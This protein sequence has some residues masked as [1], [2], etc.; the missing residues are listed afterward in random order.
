MSKKCTCDKCSP[1]ANT[2][3]GPGVTSTHSYNFEVDEHAIHVAAMNMPEGACVTI[4][5]VFTTCD[6]EMLGDVPSACGCC[7]TTLCCCTPETT[8]LY[9]GKYTA[10]LTGAEPD[11]VVVTWNPIKAAVNFTVPNGG[12]AMCC[13]QGM[14]VADVKAIVDACVAG[15]GNSPDTNVS[16]SPTADGFRVT[17]G[18]GGAPYDIPITHPD[19]PD[20]VAP[21]LAAITA[22]YASATVSE[23]RAYHKATKSAD[24]SGWVDLNGNYGEDDALRGT[25]GY[26][27]IAD[28]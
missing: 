1:D 28:L 5:R 27:N 14:S 11:D 2:L 24:G 8:L 21:T 17:P 13:N 6:G 23:R 10:Q 4:K 22:A 15:L 20:P 7:Q 19:A 3:F 26:T 12:N 9:P 16:I 18:N 25:P